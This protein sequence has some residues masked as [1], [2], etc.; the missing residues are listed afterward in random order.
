MPLLSRVLVGDLTDVGVP[1]VSGLYVRGSDGRN[2]T[3]TDTDVLNAQA[4]S[5]GSS[6]ATSAWVKTQISSSLGQEQC[7]QSSIAYEYD[8][9]TGACTSL[10]FS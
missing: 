4:V 6:S 3:V 2:C 1:G 10:T 7:P 5:L 9:V 8:T